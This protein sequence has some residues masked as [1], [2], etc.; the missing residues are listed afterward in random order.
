MFPAVFATTDG[1]SGRHLSNLQ[2]LYVAQGEQV[3]P[4]TRLRIIHAG[5]GAQ[6]TNGVHQELMKPMTGNCARVVR[7]WQ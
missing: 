4:P 7:L 2:R 1:E 5:S 3:V 6:G